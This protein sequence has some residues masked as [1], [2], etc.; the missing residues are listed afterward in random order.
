M[1]EFRMGETI[2]VIPDNDQVIDRDHPDWEYWDDLDAHERLLADDD[3]PP[4]P[5]R[6]QTVE[7]PKVALALSKSQAAAALSMSVDTFERR[8][9]PEIRVVQKG[10]KVIVPVRE[11]EAWLERSAARAL[12]GG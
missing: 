10:K 1:A 2:W 11:L 6:P 4:V 5:S 8:V 7:V 9:V 3:P 12:Q